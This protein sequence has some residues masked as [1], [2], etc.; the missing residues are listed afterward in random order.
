MR[1][2]VERRQTRAYIG[3][4]QF[5]LAGISDPEV[6]PERIAKLAA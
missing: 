4:I 2:A 5:E 1:P 6:L 3:H